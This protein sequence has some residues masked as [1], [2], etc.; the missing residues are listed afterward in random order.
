M[1]VID[2][3][4]TDFILEEILINA[5]LFKNFGINSERK[6]SLSKELRSVK[7]ILLL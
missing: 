6:T 4:I 7:E 3:L 1:S 5:N 2:T